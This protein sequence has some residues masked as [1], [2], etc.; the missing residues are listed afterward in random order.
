M[1]LISVPV[2]IARLHKLSSQRSLFSGS[3][4]DEG[5][6]LHRFIRE[7]FG[8][9]AFS[10]FR[11]FQPARSRM[12]TLYAYSHNDADHH[13]DTAS[14]TGVPDSA[15][16][17]K[18]ASMKSQPRPKDAWKPDQRIGFSIKCRATR[19]S[20]L[21]GDQ[22]T[23]RGRREAEVDTYLHELEAHQQGYI[24]DT[25]TREESYRRWLLAKLQGD[26]SP[27]REAISEIDFSINVLNQSPVYRHGKWSKGPDVTFN[28]N[29]SIKDPIAFANLLKT[30]IGK[31]K[32]YGYGMLL[33][34]PAS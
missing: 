25:P 28:G 7:T 27:H 4:F 13:R 24:T 22:V 34:R 5:A 26:G 17:F 19:K 10:T 20:S 32:A 21:V 31:H 12:G 33:L 3:R 11:L 6:A 14:C 23:G 8:A 30:G 15:E 18:L 16:L 2:D 29:L 9:S 1:H